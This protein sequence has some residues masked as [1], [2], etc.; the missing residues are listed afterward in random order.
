MIA[1]LFRNNL[2]LY[3]FAAAKMVAGK[4]V[5]EMP[6]VEFPTKPKPAEQEQFPMHGIYET[7]S[8][9]CLNQII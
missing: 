2:N 4:M 8:I 3:C 5:A 1:R 9:L 6:Q 7:L